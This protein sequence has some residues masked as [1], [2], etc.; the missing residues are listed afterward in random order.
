MANCD[1]PAVVEWGPM[2]SWQA[3]ENSYTCYVSFLS[4]VDKFTHRVCILFPATVLLEF[5]VGQFY[6]LE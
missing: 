5:S 1:H 4:H 2:H 3:S 6:Q